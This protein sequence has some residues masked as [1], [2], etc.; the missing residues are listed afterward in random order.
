MP[1]VFHSHSRDLQHHPWVLLILMNIK[2]NKAAVHQCKGC[3][4]AHIIH[5]IFWC[6]F[7]MEGWKKLI[8][9]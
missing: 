3:T 1:A 2:V 4:C 6:K 5:F 8:F 7:H 9:F